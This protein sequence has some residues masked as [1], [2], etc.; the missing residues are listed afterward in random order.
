M[1]NDVTRRVGNSFDAA[2]SHLTR[3]EI[4]IPD[5]TLELRAVILLAEQL[6][7]VADAR[8]NNVQL[9]AQFLI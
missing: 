3:L 1:D 9:E 2:G 5:D 8:T 6:A 7:E 4:P